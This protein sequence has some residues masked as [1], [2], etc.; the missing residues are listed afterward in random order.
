[1][2]C[3]L[4]IWAAC[5]LLAGTAAAEEA[6]A[7]STFVGGNVVVD[8][9]V[10]GNLHA[11]GGKITI[12]AP[13]EGNVRAAGGKVT[14]DAP[15]GGDVSVAAGSLALGPNAR[16]AGKLSFRGGRLKQDPAAVVAGGIDESSG[17]RRSYDFHPFGGF[18]AG[19]FWTAGLVLLAAILAAGLPGPMTRMTQELR[20]HPWTAPLLGFIALTCIPVAAVLVMITLIGIPLGLLAL[21]GYVAL[22]LVGYVSISVVVGGML[23]DRFNAQ[24]AGQLAWRVGAA[25][26]AM[27]ALGLVARLPFVG[28]AFAFAAL[29]VGVGLIVAAVFRR[30]PAAPTPTPTPA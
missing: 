14:I 21:L 11:A 8:E 16:I 2:V 20:A 18:R 4:G 9:A 6:A 29:I 26:L 15:V 17:H 5:A 22:L 27:L 1:M 10:P 30:T 28:G 24:A 19:W 23:L 13:V 3:R 7:K 12:T 25:M